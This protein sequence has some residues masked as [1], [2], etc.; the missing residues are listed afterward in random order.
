VQPFDQDH[1]LIAMDQIK[2]V[3]S[4]TQYQS[5]ASRPIKSDDY[6]TDAV[7]DETRI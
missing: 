6:L 1:T 5:R 7:T 4:N 3:A 2:T